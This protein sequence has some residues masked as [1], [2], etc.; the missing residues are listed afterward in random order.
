P[1][2]VR[3]HVQQAVDADLEPR[4]LARLPYGGVG[5]DLAAIDVAAREHPAAVARFDGPADQD[6]V[7]PV[8]ADD[9]P[10]R[11]LRVEI[12]DEAAGAADEAV[13]LAR[14]ERARLEWTAAERAE[15]V[16]TFLVHRHTWGGPRIIFVH[17][18][19]ESRA[20]GA[21]GAPRARAA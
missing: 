12:E 11:H 6:D 16:G 20:D 1:S 10:D 9:R 3:E 21:P 18:H 15:P 7:P 2:G 4:L 17:V 19:S 8:V 5:H 14:P 13:G